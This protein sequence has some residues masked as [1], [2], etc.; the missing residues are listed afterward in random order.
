MKKILLC[1]VLFSLALFVANAQELTQIFKVDTGGTLTWFAA[2]DTT[3]G[4]CVNPSTGNI[5]VADRDSTVGNNVHKLDPSTGADL[6][7]LDSTGISG[8]THV[9]SKID[10]ASDGVIYLCN[11]AVATADFKIYR[12]ASEVAVP[13]AAYTEAAAVNRLGDEIAVTGTGTGTKILVTGWMY[14]KLAKFTTADGLTFSKTEVTP[15]NPDFAFGDA[16]PGY[17]N[18]AWDPAGT[19]Y[20]ACKSK[21]DDADGRIFK[22]TGSTDLSTGSP[23]VTRALADSP[24]G[25]GPFTV[26]LVGSETIIAL[27]PSLTTAAT[28]TN[29]YCN[30]YDGAGTALAY[31]TGSIEKAGAMAINGNG[32]GDVSINASTRKVYVLLTNNSISG[33]NLPATGVQDWNLY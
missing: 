8:G 7:N 9:V 16:G 17:T 25:S 1:I 20:F 2:D 5:L 32:T 33:W 19:D 11:L 30:F 12:Y 15:G 27:G 23:V 4:M 3:R 14:N 18:L 6:G 26:K 21:A 28:P 24:G 29:V 22:Y 31:R 10:A 13:T